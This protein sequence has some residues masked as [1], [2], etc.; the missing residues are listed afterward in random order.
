MNKIY[1]QLD[2]IKLLW[3][4]LQHYDTR[5]SSLTSLEENGQTETEEEIL[6]GPEAIKKLKNISE[7][8][9]EIIQNENQYKNK[10]IK[11]IKGIISSVKYFC[12]ILSLDNEKYK[13]LEEI[14]ESE[15][16]IDKKKRL[17]DLELE[18]NHMV[19]ERKSI[20]KELKKEINLIYLELGELTNIDEDIKFSDLSFEYINSLKHD[21]TQLKIQQE[22]IESLKFKHVDDA[23]S[24]E[25]IP[26]CIKLFLNQINELKLSQNITYPTELRDIPLEKMIDDII[27]YNFKGNDTKPNKLP[28]SVKL[29]TEFIQFLNDIIQLMEDK[30]NY[31]MK[32]IEIILKNIRILYEDLKI[33]K[34]KQLK[35]E[36][37]KLEN[38]PIYEEELKNLSKM[39]QDTQKERVDN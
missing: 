27:E 13:N 39:W 37:D 11:Q 38:I 7:Q 24:I 32:Q 26:L 25:S 3:K 31:Y 17:Q 15:S 33:E 6:S 35:L 18:L 2:E 14:I 34:S 21:I 12:E 9:D 8:L 22:N 4:Q 20:I 28:K 29:T 36:V 23:L 19:S 30:L 10:I 5:K 1:E 16:L